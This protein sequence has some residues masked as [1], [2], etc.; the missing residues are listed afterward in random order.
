MMNDSEDAV[1]HNKD[2]PQACLARRYFAQQSEWIA[3]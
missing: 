3:R 2:Q 1:K